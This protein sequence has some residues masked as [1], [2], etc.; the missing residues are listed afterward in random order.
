MEIVVEAYKERVLH[1]SMDRLQEAIRKRKNP[2][3]L[4][5]LGDL[6][7]RLLEQADSP[8][9]AYETFCRELLTAL[10]GEI[11]ALRLSFARFALMGSQG[12]A[13]LE[14]TLK[15]AKKLGYYVLLDGPELL[16]PSA[17]RQAAQSLLGKDGPFLCDGVIL[18]VYAGSDVVEPFL[19]Y[20]REEKKTVFLVSRTAN[21]SAPELQDLITG[22]R[23]VHTAAAD[24]ALRFG[25]QCVG[26][27]GYTPVGLMVSAGSADSIRQMRSKYPQQFLL[28]DGFDTPRANAKN[29][30]YCFNK[31]GWGGAVCSGAEIS[32]AW[33]SVE[34][35][36]T[37]YVQQA[38]E[39]AQRMK[40][41]LN[42]YITMV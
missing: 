38:L 15:L 8:A 7:P 39:A 3:V 17:A 4:E 19:P 37:D 28:L 10:A 21:R 26:K 32:G 22:S 42:R 34:G 41:N 13:V 11:P 29:C 24:L 20:C 6:P 27:R 30:S 12:L 16:R 33:Q 25:E 31:Y 1:M 2:T 14:R 9:Q 5:L 35:D 23:L 18:G 36:G 40:R